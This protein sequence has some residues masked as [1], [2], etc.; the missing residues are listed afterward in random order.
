MPM[1]AELLLR[2]IEGAAGVAGKTQLKDVLW[3]TVESASSITGARYGALGVIGDH[4][5]LVEFLH[6]GLEPA[7][8]AA[9]GPLP[10]GRGVLGTITRMAKTVRIDRIQ[11]HPD[12]VGFPPNHPPME[13]FLGVPVRTGADV[14]GNLYLTEKP[15]GFS[16]EDEVVVE[17]LAVVAGSA[18]NT[19]RLQDRLRRVA[20]VEDRARIARDLHD[21]IIQDLFAA[22]LTLQAL[23]IRVDDEVTAAGLNDAVH[24]LDDVIG[25]LRGF[26]FDLQ[27]PA[28]S[29]RTLVDRVT[30][31]VAQVSEPHDTEVKVHY[32]PELKHEASRATEHVLHV[33]REALSNALRHAEADRID[34]DLGRSADGIH[35]IVRDD[36][37]GFDPAPAGGGM[38]L[39]NL[40][41][42][43]DD[44]GGTILI[45]SKPGAGTV[46]KV[47]FPD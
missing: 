44:V 30:E 6:V 34:V 9:I 46:V 29:E 20:V 41:S 19:A 12:S 21:G 23:S 33:V 4:G 27:P 14:F 22:G 26:I 11:D 45:D 13:T 16:A 10:R 38:G 3:A 36:G 24:R 40:H 28:W 15:G 32:D 39:R 1:P 35:V 37:I 18:I 17:A 2:L 31:L 47:T 8:V 42:R 7:V 25:S 5:G 43:A